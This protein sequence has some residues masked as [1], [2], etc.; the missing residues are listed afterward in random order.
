MYGV[1][2]VPLPLII[3]IS[4]FNNITGRISMLELIGLSIFI[5]FS[6]IE[7]IFIVFSIIF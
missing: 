1:L 6:L 7:I 5:F 2:F 3:E 4:S